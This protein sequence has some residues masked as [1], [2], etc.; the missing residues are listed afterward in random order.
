MM[1]KLKQ[2]R[3]YTVTLVLRICAQPSKICHCMH[4]KWLVWAV[5]DS[6]GEGRGAI[7]SPWC[8]NV[9]KKYHKSALMDDPMVEKTAP[10]GVPFQW[11]KRGDV[12]FQKAVNCPLRCLFIGQNVVKC[13][14]TF[15]MLV[16]HRKQQVPFY[17]I[18]LFSPLPVKHPESV[19]GL[20]KQS[21]TAVWQTNSQITIKTVLEAS[22]VSLH[23]WH[24]LRHP[25]SIGRSPALFRTQ[26]LFAFFTEI[27]NHYFIL[28]VLF[29][30]RHVRDIFP[31]WQVNVGYLFYMT[32]P[33]CKTNIKADYLHYISWQ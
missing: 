10:S 12:P 1:C 9:G 11:T 3:P 14:M 20:E 16:S 19:S 17:T 26:E 8:P 30:L 28:T 15:G 13:P 21:W 24:L 27:F 5:A 4:C 2:N 18:L 33:L 22:L 29:P 7:T 25:E 32:W 6:E 23:T 31:S